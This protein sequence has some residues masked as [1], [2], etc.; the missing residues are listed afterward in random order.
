M[1]EK[2]LKRLSRAELLELLLIQTR[3]TEKLRSQ[4]ARAAKLLNDRRI[5]IEKSSDLAQAVLSVNS[6]IDAATTAAN[7][8]LY[9]IE[10]MEQETKER[11]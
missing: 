11:C 5:A 7:Q 6:V 1:T 2:E 4:L 10:I 9:N 3:E 8:Y